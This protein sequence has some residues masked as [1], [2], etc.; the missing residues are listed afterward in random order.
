MWI[1]AF[2]FFQSILNGKFCISVHYLLQ[3]ANDWYCRTVTGEGG[4]RSPVT[5][6]KWI[7]YACQKAD[8]LDRRRETGEAWVMFLIFQA[9]MTL[10]H[11][12]PAHKH[13]EPEKK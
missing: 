2:L 8:T 10:R 11:I 12:W 3:K 1:L 7:L 5:Q 6:M 4:W 13:R 9:F